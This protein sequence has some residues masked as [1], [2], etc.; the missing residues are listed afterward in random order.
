M[1]REKRPARLILQD[2]AI[3]NGYRFGAERPVSGE[4]VFNTGMVGYP[5]SLTDPSYRGQILVLTYPL[6]GNYGVPG[7]ELEEGLSRRFESE[8][9]QILGLVVAGYSHDYSHW[10][11]SRS[12]SEWMVE[13]GVP[14]IY[15]IDTRELTKR[16][17]EHG[18]L[19]G[20]IVYEKDEI[21][22]DEPYKRNLVKDASVAEPIEY[23]RGKQRIILVDC[24]VKNNIIRAFTQ[25]EISVLRC[26]WD[27]DFSGDKADGIVISNGP[28]DPKMCPETIEN[29][30]KA[31]SRNVPILGICL[32]SQIL[33]LA[34]GA[35]TYK[36]K[37]GHRSQN[38]PCVETGTRRCYITSQNHGYA[39]D[40]ETLPEDWR[41][42]FYNGNDGTNEGLVHISKPFFGTQFHPE[43]SPGPD[44]S[45]F[46]FDMFVRAMR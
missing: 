5:E 30:R 12:L 27:Y 44:D 22:F 37:Y 2:G 8:R 4:V 20:K 9:I 46:L 24:G 38:Q 1:G 26:P 40:A 42:W 29:V 19:A 28:G 39:V 14:G 34:A 36:L 31:L 21:E 16:L 43:A 33:A 7:D 25:R 11:A 32:G 17:R 6:I 18:T 35:N 41:E 23:G 15:G 3:F 45:E 10:S 13:H